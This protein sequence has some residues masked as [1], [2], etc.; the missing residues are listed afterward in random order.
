[1]MESLEEL[2]LKTAIDLLIFDLPVQSQP[3]PVKP[4]IHS[5]V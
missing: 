2:L 5:H 4:L 1:M 3:F